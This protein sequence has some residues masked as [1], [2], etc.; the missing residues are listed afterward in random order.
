MATHQ[1]NAQDTNKQRLEPVSIEEYKKVNW[2]EYKAT[3]TKKTIDVRTKNEKEKDKTDT[4]TRMM[5]GLTEQISDATEINGNVLTIDLDETDKQHMAIETFLNSNP[6]MSVEVLQRLTQRQTSNKQKHYVDIIGQSKNTEISEA[7]AGKMITLNGYIE[8][9]TEKVPRKIK[10]PWFCQKGHCTKIEYRRGAEIETPLNCSEDDCRCRPTRQAKT[11]QEALRYGGVRESGF[12]AM[13]QQTMIKTEKEIETKGENKDDNTRI[14]GEWNRSHI[15]KVEE[16]ESAHITGI[17]RYDDDDSGKLNYYLHI[18]GVE[19]EDK[20]EDLTDEEIHNVKDWVNDTDLTDRIQG[21]DNYT[22]GRVN[23]RLAVLC[24]AVKGN[25]GKNSNIHTLLIGPSGTGKTQLSKKAIELVEG[26]ETVEMK[27]SSDSGVTGGVVKRK[28]LG[29]ENFVVKHGAL[30]RADGSTVLIDELDKVDRSGAIDILSESM[31]SQTCTIQKISSKVLKTDVSIIGTCNPVDEW[32]RKDLKQ[33]AIPNVFQNH[34]LD[35]F[36][37]IIWMDKA[38]QNTDDLINR[39]TSDTEDE[40]YEQTE[41]FRNWIK[42]AKKYNPKLESES[43]GID[44]LR[45]CFNELQSTSN[46]TEATLVNLSQAIA[47][48]NLNETVSGDDVKQAWDLWTDY[49][50]EIEGFEY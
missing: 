23:C 24:S 42:L 30:A 37:L 3:Y 49:K 34:I 33:D 46:R 20:T 12:K 7:N 21:I 43:D 15:G 9:V 40:E 48:L 38:E 22:D 26:G 16:G 35:R 8:H 4:K 27:K 5:A 36:D 31:E 10:V 41:R 2:D 1:E 13:I 11:I 47:K 32:G 29:G 25:H 14:K 39:L 17:L 28:M 44:E 50:N 45:Q 19:H 18:L 6:L